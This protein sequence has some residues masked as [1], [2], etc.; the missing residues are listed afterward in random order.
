MLIDVQLSKGEGLIEVLGFKIFSERDCPNALPP[1][2]PSWNVP[3][4][5]GLGE[6]P[7]GLTALAPS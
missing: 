3:E 7:G 2:P 4:S 6:R 1:G 5:T